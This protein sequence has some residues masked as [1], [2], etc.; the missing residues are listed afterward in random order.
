[1]RQKLYQ[2]SIGSWRKYSSQ[3]EPVIKLLRKDLAKLKKEGALGFDHDMKMN[4]K[5]EYN[6]PDYVSESK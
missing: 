5:V 1:M 6:H 4:W 2:S 3:L